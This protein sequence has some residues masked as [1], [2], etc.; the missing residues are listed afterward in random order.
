VLQGDPTHS[1]MNRLLADHF[2]KKGQTG[3]ANFYESRISRPSSA[4]STN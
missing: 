2:R 1:A 3:L 4:V